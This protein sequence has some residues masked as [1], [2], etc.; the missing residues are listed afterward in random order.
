[1]A[2]QTTPPTP[3]SPMPHEQP[4]LSR[5]NFLGTASALAAGALATGAVGT[6]AG[7]AQAATGTPHADPVG[8]TPA[9]WIWY[10][11]GDP[12][13][14]APTGHRYFRTTFTVAKGEVTDAQLV[15]TGDDT[16]DVWLNG[17][18]LA[19]SPRAARSWRNALY[20]DLRSAVTT[21]ANT[22]ALA[23]RNQGGGAGVIGRLRV[24][25]TGGTTEVVTDG[26]WAAGKAVSAGWEQPGSSVEGWPTARDLGA[27]GT[28]PWY[29]QVGAP[30]LTAPSPLTVATC[31]VER[32]AAPLGV[33]AVHPRFGW[34]LDSTEQQQRQGGYRIQVSSTARGSGDLWDTG[35]V[36]SDRQ[37]DIAYAGKPLK[38][39]TRCFWRVRVWDVQGRASS[40]SKPQWF[41]TG[42][43]AAADEWSA[44]F[45]GRPPGPDLSGAT[46]IWYPEG[47]PA[48]GVPAATR[49]FRRTFGLASAPAAATLIVTGDDTADVWVNGTP[50]S[51]SRRVTDSWKSAAL[52]DVTAHLRSGDNTIAVASRNT[53]PSPAGLIA[54][55]TVPG[56]PT[57]VT[58]GS[59]KTHQD[60]P[61]GWES[62]AY[63]D[64]DWPASRAVA[65]YGGGPWGSNVRVVGPAPL[66]R[67][68]FTVRGRVASARLLTTALGLHETRLNGA[69]VGDDVLAP[70]WTDYTKRVQYKVFDVTA[71][72]RRGA[73]ALGAW[74]GNGWYSGSLGFAGSR[75][76]GTQPFYAAQLLI[77][78]TD[79]STQLVRTD[80]SWKTGTGAIT[81][82]DL[83][84]GE[85]YDARL[86]AE[87]WDSAGF[88]DSGW[89]TAVVHEGPTPPLVAQ[90]DNGVTVQH[91]F[92]SV[93][94]T[95]PQPGVWI[96]DMGQN[97]TGWNRIAVRGAAGTTVTVR[98]G[99][100]LNP[101]GTLYTTNL[102]A[103]Q[104]TDVFTLA[105]TG[106]IETYEPR[107]TVHGYRYVELSGLP[108]D[109]RPGDTTVTGRAVWTNAGQPGTFSTSDALINKLQHNIVW[110]ER[111]NMLSIPTDCPQRDERLGWTGD[112]AAFCATSAF[113]LNTHTLL[114]KFVDD[115]ADA[116][117]ANGAFTDVAPAVIGGSG[118]AGWGDA[119]TIIPYTLWQR[120]GDLTVVERHFTAMAKWVDYLHNTSGSDLIRNQQTFGDWLNVN[121]DTAQDLICTAYFAWS[122]RLVSRMA[123]ATGRSAEATAYGQLADQV[124][125]AFRARFV[126]DEGTV[127]GDTQ[128][129][130]VL[131]LAFELLPAALARPAADKLAARVAATDGHLSV[132]FLGVENLLPVLAD[133]GHV[134]TAYRILL[135]RGFPGW[136]YMIDHGATTIWE[137]WDGIRAD[138]SFNDPGMNSFNHY[139]LG[140]VGD[141][142][143]RQV[144]GLSPSSP[145]YASLRIAPRPGGGLTSAVST[146][147][148]PYGSA[149]SSWSVSSGQLRLRVTVPV[150]TFAAVTVPTPRP[151][152]VVAPSQA[153]PT[154][155]AS[156]H[157]P[158]GS[159]T[160]T[161]AA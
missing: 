1:M 161:A 51:T 46:W 86:H 115:M 158:A 139:G 101:D 151:E 76:Y 30:D 89:A 27:Y 133:H 118:T 21:G 103:A 117:Q 156:Y 100:V 102:R 9:H 104:A 77:T 23:S 40:W 3:D 39:L 112:I 130:Y 32:L 81:S 7:S 5:R 10:P 98:H 13:T 52:V 134:E 145:G 107:F 109:F 108:S 159:Y 123:A 67:K 144:G 75:R 95:Q 53:S 19:G 74:L 72:I 92:R 12:G 35:H 55:L 2:S 26:R 49:F 150:N 146:Y 152:S 80:G 25:T 140:S 129:G 96:F 66:L 136:G 50:V 99:E 88:D 44:A 143:Y 71:H 41:E 93:S 42:L 78:F 34:V 106:S 138:G 69:K 113:N 137:R 126:T 116:Q 62:S 36:A 68:S 57:V 4:P 121:D 82:D 119:G 56:G 154:G 65:P 24:L 155:P 45:I 125:A 91:E 33:D 135:Q 28:A 15:V 141:F 122:A 124:A 59:W 153:V 14:E 54:K 105:G 79:G 131:A 31:T 84:H 97:F 6:L 8:L 64:G 128:T 22:I 16:V 94:L 120:F 73:N 132:G 37:I 127:R 149:A 70:G 11:E 20:V 83:Y 48:S 18:P 60:A 90:V 17:K 63:D 142:L 58:D 29:N 43:L 160:F 87:G 114:A 110:G 61:S 111:G 38:S 157:L 85:T 47:D 148:T 147:A